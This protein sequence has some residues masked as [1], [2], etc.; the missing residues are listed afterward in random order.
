MVFSQ[1]VEQGLGRV[2]AINSEW[3]GTKYNSVAVSVSG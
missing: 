2:K 1:I 3:N